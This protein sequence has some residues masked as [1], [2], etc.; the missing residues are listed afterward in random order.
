MYLLLLIIN[1]LLMNGYLS[2]YHSLLLWECSIRGRNANSVLGSFLPLLECISGKKLM[3]LFKKGGKILGNENN[4]SFQTILVP[5]DGSHPSLHAE[6]L[7][8]PI[9]KHFDSKV[10]VLHTVSRD[11]IQ[12]ISSSSSNIPSSIA[13]ELRASLEQKGGQIIANA[14]ALYK[15]ENIPVDTKLI[16]YG[17]PAE[18]ILDYCGKYDLIVMGGRGEGGTE[19]FE[20]G[21]VAKKIIRHSECPVLL[22]KKRAPISKILVPVDGSNYSKKALKY[23]IALAQKHNAA[24]T[25]VNAA[26]GASPVFG[27]DDAEKVGESILNE[28][29]QLVKVQG[30][31][32][33]TRLEF[34]APA[35]I[36]TELAEKENYDLIIMGSRGRSGIRRFLLGGVSD[37]VA[38]ASKTSILIVK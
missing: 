28:D 6:E 17:D 26:K 16:E 1:E 24:L 22:V 11:M 38:H 4:I 27:R 9:A 33:E 7:V 18:S 23:A 20:L 10:T 25:L 14:K 37:K 30:L 34:G 19:E 29:K 8:V 32:P 15:E 12:L 13:G 35:K 3:I 36:I 5:V 31:K 2:N 21:S